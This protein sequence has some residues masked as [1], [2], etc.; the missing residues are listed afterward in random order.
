MRRSLILLVCLLLGCPPS[1]PEEAEQ[2]RAAE[3]TR[4]EQ[5]AR[6][7]AEAMEFLGHKEANLCFARVPANYATWGAQVPCTPQVCRLLRGE[8]PAACG[9]DQPDSSAR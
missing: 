5:R 7:Q 4:R 6:D 9:P 2:E 3:A 8:R 1:T